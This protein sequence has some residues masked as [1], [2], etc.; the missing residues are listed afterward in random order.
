MISQK[1]EAPKPIGVLREIE[2]LNCQRCKSKADRT[3]NSD[4]GLCETTRSVLDSTSLRCVGEWGKN[5]VLFLHH[6]VEIV[7]NAMKNKKWNGIVYLEI[8]S[9]PG[10]CLDRNGGNEF[11]GSPLAV[12]RSNGIEH[13]S[14]IIFVDYDE[15][16]I[17]TLNQRIS[18]LPELDESV[19]SKTL[20][21]QG[22]YLDEENLIERIKPHIPK[23]SLIVAFV[24]PTDFSVPFSLIESL[25]SFGRIDFIINEAIY[26]D[27]NRNATI[28]YRFRDSVPERK[29]ER[30]LG[31]PGFFQKQEYKE[32]AERNDPEEMRMLFHNAY[33][34]QF[35]KLGYSHHNEKKIAW[36]YYLLYLSKSDLGLKF[37]KDAC[38]KDFDGQI[39]L[40]F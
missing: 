37:W 33:L 34:S 4:N 23:G 35:K 25:N 1:E 6:Y 2:N 15:K 7:G 36:F 27:Y 20:V 32:A 39:D 24:D 8:C 22:N 14:K 28:P 30:A 5:K 19:K 29:W 40:P 38:K 3:V 16:V 26:T 17:E 10:R 12:L 11:D 31:I 13:F 18:S 9:G 21:L